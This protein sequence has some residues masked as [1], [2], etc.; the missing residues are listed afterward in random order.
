METLYGFYDKDK[1][2]KTD[3]GNAV[4]L[5]KMTK[6]QVDKFIAENG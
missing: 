1:K 4:R 3:N 2:G 6:K 5:D